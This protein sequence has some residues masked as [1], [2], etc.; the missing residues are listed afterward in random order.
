MDN[1]LEAYERKSSNTD[2]LL[3]KYSSSH[4]QKEIS[5]SKS[6]G[7][8]LARRNSDF[9][10]IDSDEEVPSRRLQRSKIIASF[11]EQLDNNVVDD[12]FGDT[13]ENGLLE[14]SSNN[15]SA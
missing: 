12:D 7:V 6:T 15:T 10:S 2:D 14:Q 4:K 13:E 3:A 1:H 9:D 8:S 11:L 5:R